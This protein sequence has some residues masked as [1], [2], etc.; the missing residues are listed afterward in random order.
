MKA[1][2]NSVSK[3]HGYDYWTCSGTDSY[4]DLILKWVG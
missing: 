1:R 3:G 4:Y 2:E